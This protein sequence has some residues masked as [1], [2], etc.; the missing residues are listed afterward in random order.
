MIRITDFG[1]WIASKNG[2]WMHA[3]RNPGLELVY[4]EN[5]AIDWDYDGQTV[6]V[7]PKQVSF[8]WPWETHGT[9][10]ARVPT[11]ELYW[12]VLPLAKAYTRA[13]RHVHLHPSFNIGRDEEQKLLTALRSPP[14]PVVSAS[15][16]LRLA[17][18][19]LVME[20][21]KGASTNALRVRSLVLLILS[22]IAT[23]VDKQP[24]ERPDE[25]VARVNTFL[26]N[27]RGSCDELWTLD[28]MAEA[29]DLGRTRF[30]LLV[31][32]VSGESPIQRLNRI[33][34]AKAHDLLLTT[35]GTITD[36][37][38]ACGFSSSQYFST[39]FRQFYSATPSEVRKR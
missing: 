17:F 14:L 6:P 15:A 1:Q 32:E 24:T 38:F 4:V 5:G 19:E 33:R 31:K 21:T 22:E 27:L 34:I 20:L 8:S 25:A 13:D 2:R 11:C 36:I 39:V 35:D 26:A 30:T 16:L 9:V 23:S 10:D 29:C 28:S 18:P 37:A 7:A 3:H 12:V